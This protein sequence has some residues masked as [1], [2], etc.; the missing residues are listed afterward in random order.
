MS[1]SKEPRAGVQV[2]SRVADVL[3][4]LEN[5]PD[6]LSLTQ[7]AERVGL[8]R[9]TVH[10]LVVALAQEGFVSAASPTARV[11][12][13]PTLARLGAASRRDMRDELDPYLRQL[14]D[15]F[16]ETVGLSI[17]DGANVRS[18]ADIQSPHLL[19]AV[20]VEGSAYPLHSVASGQSFLAAMPRG[21]VDQWL[22]KR[23]PA[24]T[25]NT[26][27]SRGDLFKKL[28]EVRRTGLAIVR[29]EQTPGVSA[30]SA[31]VYDGHGPAAAI[32]VIAPAARFDAIEAP[33][34][35]RML[36][37]SAAATKALGGTPQAAVESAGQLERLLSEQSA[38]S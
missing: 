21:E 2:V 37:V 24:L 1:D 27:T 31:M 34:S 6:G 7:I 32:S 14:A 20:S 30:V 35:A 25:P 10:R 38:A 29:E 9:S 8:A 3:R 26:Y 15:E 36:E 11:R 4:A 22:P 18:I 13:G 17:L 12:L 19:R 23:L 16:Q 28:D 5:E 33:L